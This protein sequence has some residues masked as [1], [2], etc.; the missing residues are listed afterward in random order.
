MTSPG[1]S[2]ASNPAVEPEVADTIAAF[3]RFN[4]FYTRLL[5]LFGNSYVSSRLSLT[6]G[7]VLFELAT[8]GK[9]GATEIAGELSLDP[10]YLSRI[11]RKFEEKGIIARSTSPGDAR[12]AVLRLTRKGRAVF[13]DLDRRSAQQARGVLDPLTPGT[14]AALL[15][16]MHTIEAAL[17]PRSETRAPFILR[18]HRPGD[19]GWIVSRNGAVYAQQYGWDE[20]FEALVARICADF[21]NSF[22][23]KRERCW[24]A[25]RDGERLGCIFL[26]RHPEQEG[27]AKLRMLF[28]EPAA[29]GLGL[30]RALVAECVGFARAA[31]YK[32]VTL[33][34]QSILAAAHH[35]YAQA[36]FK[37]VAEEPHHS[38][39]KDLTGQTW[40]LE[41]TTPA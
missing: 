24:I 4:R 3:R 15:K 9:S 23:G 38:F 25:E 18:T 29:R 28:V 21:I 8:R 20:T 40:D 16:S 39:G 41:L 31:G 22:D 2:P 35:I 6:E 11:L 17:A 12:N 7:R 10:G 1:T 13:A 32:R 30:G 33:W 14:R 36:G 37:L 5:G 34:T 26:V 19:M 27:T